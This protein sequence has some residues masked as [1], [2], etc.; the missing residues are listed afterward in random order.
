[1]SPPDWPDYRGRACWH[2]PPEQT[3]VFAKSFG[4]ITFFVAGGIVCLNGYRAA[5]PPPLKPGEAYCGNCI[6][7]GYV[8]MFFVAPV[9]A[10]V[11]SLAAASVGAM[12]DSVRH[13]G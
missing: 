5:M 2:L 8:V 13:K 1:M 9:A 4:V 10:V 11:S 3:W 7:G 12:I 6:I